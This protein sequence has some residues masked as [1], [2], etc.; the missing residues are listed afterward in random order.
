VARVYV[1]IGS[2]IERECNIRAGVDDLRRHYGVLTLS[3][4]YESA[5]VGFSG[6]NF[7][8]LAAGFD[9]DED[10]R[11]VAHT[12]RQIEERHGRVRSGPRFSSR[13]L[14]IDLL[15]YD[16][17]IL[18]EPGVVVPRDEIT[19]NAFVLGPLAEIASEVEHPVL[20]L[21][22]RELWQVFDK[23][24]QPLWEIKFDRL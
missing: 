5:A 24:L 20:K 23:N 10:V 8:N 4:V 19:K 16:G 9:T 13:T 3:S 1:S 7:Y 6:A 14:D 15:L 18:T 17:L 2:N 12:L 22:F 21:R 11:T